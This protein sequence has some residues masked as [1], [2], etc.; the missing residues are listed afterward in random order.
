[1]ESG[2]AEQ[3]ALGKQQPELSRWQLSGANRGLAARLKHFQGR[4]SLSQPCLWRGHGGYKSPGAAA[5]PIYSACSNRT[6]EP[7]VRSQ[8]ASLRR[9]SILTRAK[10]SVVRVTAQARACAGSCAEP[11]SVSNKVCW[12]PSLEPRRALGQ[13]T[14]WTSR[15]SP[16]RSWRQSRNT[17]LP[18]S[19]SPASRHFTPS[20]RIASR[21][22]GSRCSHSRIVT[23][24]SHVNGMCSVLPSFA[25][26]VVL[27]AGTRVLNVALL[28]GLG[29]SA[30]K[31]DPCRAVPT[32]VDSIAGTEVDSVLEDTAAHAPCVGQIPALNARP[33]SV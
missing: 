20:S 11:C 27:P 8:P 18:T 5:N 9:A 25:Q 22:P 2:G 28:A 7:S 31:D 12:R 19:N 30:E 10:A 32:E 17:D 14:A 29:S 24:K 4:Q 6:L 13:R 23:L 33:D 16:S 21:K 1:M 15:R 26:S 3:I